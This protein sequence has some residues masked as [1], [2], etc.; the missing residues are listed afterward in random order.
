MCGQINLMY[1]KISIPYFS[2]I[3]LMTIPRKILIY[4]LLGLICLQAPS[5]AQTVASVISVRKAWDGKEGRQPNHVL[6]KEYL[7]ELEV[8][9]KV[10][11]AY[12][13]ELVK[14]VQV[15]A[16]LVNATK[17]EIAIENSLD[18]ILK[19]LKIQYKKSSD[20]FYIL[21]KDNN[22]D[23]A[24]L[25]AVPISLISKTIGKLPVQTTAQMVSISGR[26]T[27]VINGEGIPGVNV[28]LKG[29]NIGTA[30]AADGG[31]KVE[32]PAAEGTLVFSYIGFVTQEIPVGSQAVIDV[33]LAENV[34]ALSEVVVTAL[35]IARSE[36][37]L[38]YSVQNIETKGMDQAR[39]TN[40]VNA[41][42]GKVSGVQITGASG[43]IGGS[44][45]VVIRGANSVSGNNQPLFVVDGTPLDNS[46][47]NSVDTQKGNGGRDYGN[48]AQD[49]N[50]D[51]IESISIL[52][53]PSAAALYGSR[54]SNG[55]ILV[56]TKS[57]K[58]VKG[59]GVSFNSSSTFEKVYMLPKYQNDYGG[60][61]KQSFDTYKGEPVVNFSA[62][63]SWGP[64]LD[65]RQVRQWESFFPGES[66]GKTTPWI[67]HPDNV[68]DF[69]ETGKT[70]SNSISL[71]G[72]NDKADMR[73]SYTNVSQ[74]GTL[75]NSRLKR[76]TVSVNA[77]AKLSSKLTASI[78]ANYVNNYVHGRPVAGDYVGTGAMSV[79]SSFNTWF[80]RQIDLKALKNYRAPDGSLRNW[81]LS[82]PEDL[83]G[84]YWNNP[85]FELYENYSDDTRERVF[86]NV[87]LAYA[88]IPHL[89]ITGYART[90]F[91]D[92]RISE[93]TAEGSVNGSM[94]VEDNRKVKENN[95]EI[96]AQYNPKLGDDFSLTINAGANARRQSYFQNY[97]RT[98]GGLNVPNFFNL[99]ASVDRPDI[100]D[101]SSKR[102]V[103]SVYGSTTIGFRDIVYLDASLRNDWS[104]TLPINNN[105]YLYP[106]VSSSFV[107][108]EL[109][110]SLDFLSFGKV[111]AGWARVGN[112]TD[113]YRLGIT[114]MP[115]TAFG[116]KQIFSVPD[117]L[118]NA[119]LKPER[120]TSYEFGGDLRFFKN[121][122]GLDVTYYSVA[123]TDQILD[124]PVSGTTGYGFAIVNA[125]K[126][127]NH[128]IELSLTGTP[129]ELPNGLKWDVTLNW[130]RNKNK[131]EF[132]ADG[133]ENYQ[134]ANAYSNLS[135]NAR[136]GETYGVMVGMGYKLNDKGQRLVDE[137]G[138]Y[139][140]ESGKVLGNT[141]PAFTGGLNNA[142]QYKNLSFS[143][144][145]DF[146]K[147]GK[148]Y[149][150]TSAT[151]GYAGL[152]AKTAGLNDKGVPQRDPV[153]AGGGVRA[154]GVLE[155]GEPNNTYIDAQAYWKDMDMV[156]EA[157]IFDGSFIKLREVRFGY[158]FPKRLFGKLPIQK[159]TLSFVGRN[160]A[161]LLRNTDIFDPETTL[162]S[163]NIQG[164]ES[165][166]LPSARS[167]GFNLNVSF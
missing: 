38:G 145:I 72:G 35:G 43:N 151:G 160:L 138:Y 39:E 3:H 10:S 129:V 128:G 130:A 109:I 25:R 45:R 81:N 108:S 26:V 137:N 60:G 75:P 165:A 136:V 133:Q 6:L 63:E 21:Y 114:Y 65:G 98:N 115:G 15:D 95:Y 100:L 104:S 154:D 56:T 142:L 146:R 1:V 158:T 122:L 97:G 90:D 102:S 40:F 27:E 70:F 156:N 131:V 80:E 143:T 159:L 67:A 135:I 153:N 106:A 30:T 83:N 48:A 92:L 101:Y 166:Q 147:G 34:H 167:L 71:M 121:R 64:K 155:S 20:N 117:V 53:G 22:K 33:K 150:V 4:P 77:S 141:L 87:S 162:G 55:V 82:G 42:Q 68:K 120:T 118:N 7:K 94:Y 24:S 85:Y 59:L 37:S 47:P 112:D 44:S 46:S 132:L 9:Y 17:K 116:S 140:K 163:G 13:T 79:V 113:P 123:T 157:N 57:G 125:G 111:R 61:F 139:I 50:P 86:G 29:T 16:R 66:F 58:N 8:K 69:Y 78:K 127:S 32:L 18:K 107:F 62:D 36:K 99:Q 14:D 76:N 51:D 105:S 84:F 12:P 103:N 19:D 28:L 88:P 93:R 152:L 148:I 144:L 74:K 23:E 161:V 164:I 49:I 2:T 89:T 126:I 91:Y 41:L 124:L 134:L 119:V 149:S 5:R 52:K 96:L 110:R 11:I 31:Y 73:L 54:A